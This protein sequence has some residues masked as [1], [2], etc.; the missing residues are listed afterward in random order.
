MFARP[1]TSRAVP[2]RRQVWC[3][4]VACLFVGGQIA[5]GL[6][7]ATETHATCPEHGETIHVTD[8][9][10]DAGA[11]VQ[12]S[13]DHRDGAS[14]DPALPDERAHEHEHCYL[15]PNTRERAA[16]TRVDRQAPAI[17][18]TLDPPPFPMVAAMVRGEIYV[19]APKNSPPA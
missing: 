3:A 2:L 9:P 19:I 16:L 12:A 10:A 7:A 5:S 13:A 17:G 4:V 8:H 18:D 15:C 1:S 6:H 14:V 11:P